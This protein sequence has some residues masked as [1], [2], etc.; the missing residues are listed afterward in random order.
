M[1]K[2]FGHAYTDIDM[3]K[4]GPG[5]IFM[6]SFEGVKRNFGFKDVDRTYFEVGPLELDCGANPKYDDDEAT[7][8]IPRWVS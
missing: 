4:R 3:K 1:T 2:Q 8:K 6:K 5:S 7:V